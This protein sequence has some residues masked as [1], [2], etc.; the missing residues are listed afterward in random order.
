MPDELWQL[1]DKNLV[2]RDVPV[3]AGRAGKRLSLNYSNSGVL[4]KLLKEHGVERYYDLRHFAIT[5]LLRR[6]ATM[7][8]GAGHKNPAISAKYYTHL[9]GQKRG[10]SGSLEGN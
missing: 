10:L 9:L 7:A 2:S 6:G 3:I 5:N 4:L 1:L 8:E